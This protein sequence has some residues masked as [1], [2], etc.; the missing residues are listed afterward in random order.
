MAD[1]RYGNARA[2]TRGMHDPTPLSSHPREKLVERPPGRMIPAVR[3][4]RHAPLT[5]LIGRSREIAAVTQLLG[6][7]DVRLITI[8]GPGGVGKTRLALAVAEQVAAESAESVLIL[9]LDSVCDPDHVLPMAARALGLRAHDS[10]SD[11]DVLTTHLGERSFLLVLDN[12]EQIIDVGVALAE[13]LRR[14]RGLTILV[15]SRVPLN[16]S[17]EQLFPL[18][19]LTVL[20]DTESLDQVGKAVTAD[21]AATAPAVM[22]F[23]KRAQAVQPS[24]KLT[25][26]NAPFVTAICRQL[27]GLPLAIELAAARSNVLSPR[28]IAARLQGG[29]HLLSGGPVDAPARHRTLTDTIAWSYDLLDQHEQRIF[30]GLGVFAGGCDQ[31]AVERVVAIPPAA[32][33]LDQLTTLVDKSLI[34]SEIGPGDEPRFTML[35]TVREFALDQLLAT[36]EDQSIREGH[37]AWFLDLAIAANESLRQGDDLSSWLARLEADHDNLR[38]AMTWALTQNRTKDALRLA[39][40]LWRFWEAH[41]HLREGSEWLDRILTVAGD[42]PAGLRARAL[43]NLGNLISQFGDT[44]RVREVYEQS[45]RLWRELGDQQGIADTLNNLAILATD[46]GDYTEARA[47]LEESLAHRRA[48]GDEVGLILAIANLGDVAVAEGALDEASDL[49]QQAFA[50]RRA[51]DDARGVAYSELNLGLIALLRGNPAAAE[52]RLI[53]SLQTFQALGDKLGAAYALRHLA[54]AAHQAGRS[55]FALLL[56]ALQLRVE[57]DDRRGI[58]DC[59]EGLALTGSVAEHDAVTLLSAARTLRLSVGV[60]IPAIEQRS[61]DELLNNLRAH[62]PASE[63]AAAWDSGAPLTQPQAVAFATQA[64]TVTANEPDQPRNAIAGGLTEREVDV[65]RLV[66]QGLTNIDIG[67]RLFL[68]PRTVE[69]HLHRIYRKLDV[70]SRTAAAAFAL[71]HNLVNRD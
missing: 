16:V 51:R 48:L 23:V 62:L 55:S 30:R 66:A 15:T 67:E 29:L 41:G 38:S 32:T 25:D 53:P 49:H 54:L 52:T 71:D 2:G 31:Q 13:L 39:S 56:D 7:P 37:L 70:P 3:S 19:P 40:S 20:G 21:Q 34:R 10:Q 47:M 22:L 33:M 17:D 58:A 46:R 27:D 44:I 35:E 63:F 50:L 36:G 6:R 26:D 11:L 64:A 69:A 5:P 59:L 8:L 42:A 24:F 68:S 1:D 14:A 43:N 9:R 4:I 28:A 45:L 61:H 12:L 57:L 65:L 18:A 60:P